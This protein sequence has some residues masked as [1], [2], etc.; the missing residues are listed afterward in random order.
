MTLTINLSLTEVTIS[1]L[2]AGLR[3]SL[4]EVTWTMRGL[5]GPLAEVT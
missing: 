4:S 3:G 2:T 5:R 1:N